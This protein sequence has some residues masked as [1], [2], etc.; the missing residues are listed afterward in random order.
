MEILKIRKAVL[1]ELAEIEK[2]YAYARSFMAQNG[3]ATQWG[4]TNP[5]RE[6]L[7]K[8]IADENL[9][10]I[11]DAERI[12]GVFAF[13]LGE[14]P[15]YGYIEGSWHHSSPY[16]TIHRIASNGSHKGILA[17]CVSYCESC[18]DHLR[19]DTHENNRIMQHL[20]TSLGFSYC[21]IIYLASG[22]PRLV[23][24]RKKTPHI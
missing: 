12:C 8:D 19:I 13:I 1:S 18:I 22:S 14:D 3:N 23:Y 5:T 16:G 2:I 20:V 10:V 15:T 21:G 9:Y 24:D 6:M 7:L 11:R 17:R 4:T